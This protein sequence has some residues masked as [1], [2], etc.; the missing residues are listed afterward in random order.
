M[1]TDTITLLLALASLGAA[2][3]NT[4]SLFLPGTVPQTIAASIVGQD[5]TATTYLVGCRDGAQCG[6]PPNGALLTEG[7]STYIQSATSLG[8][9]IGVNCNINGVSRAVCTATG[10][11]RIPTGVQSGQLSTS[12]ATTTLSPAQFSFYQVPVGS[13]LF[14]GASSTTGFT[15]FSST[16]TGSTTF[17]TTF[18]SYPYTTS[19]TSST[20]SSTTGPVSFTISSSTTST[21]T[22]SSA[23][24]MP[25]MTASP[26][27]LV[28]GAA[29]ALALAA[30]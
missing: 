29:V 15:L 26:Q 2:Q 28:G 30:L 9:S 23:A 5:A 27:W 7:P 4:I 13:N 20:S 24:G 21:N 11:T 3:S 25:H 10:V 22:S 12:T 16:T 19:T 1:L 18:N 8:L 6:F 14:T 17:P